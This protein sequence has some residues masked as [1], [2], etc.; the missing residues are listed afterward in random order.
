MN[1]RRKFLQQIGLTAGAF[2]A[3]SLFNQLHAENFET[4]NNKVQGFSADAVA[5]D[6]DYWSVIQ[7]AYTVSP[8]IINLNNGGVSP[9]PRVVQEAVERY[10]KLSNEGPSYFMWR[11]LDMGR[12]PLR[13]KLAA[14]AGCE[15]RKSTR[16]NS[17]HLRLSR[18]P[19]SA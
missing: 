11:I 6:E 13:Q 10:N 14:L 8:N 16:L 12:E 4:A 1:N 7:Q 2:S 3:S 5:G 15:D 17:S 19:S 9:S 18:M